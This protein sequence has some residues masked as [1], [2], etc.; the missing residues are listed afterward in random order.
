VSAQTIEAPVSFTLEIWQAGASA[1]M[2]SGETPASSLVCAL[3]HMTVD[4]TAAV[5]NPVRVRWA[6]PINVLNDCELQPTTFL[7]SVPI[8]TSYRATVVANGATTRSVRSAPS[9]PFDRVPVPVP[10]QVP[11]DVRLGR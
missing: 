7:F 10:P 8:G 1:P 9:N 11:T 2:L 6:D 4:P 5:V 3:P